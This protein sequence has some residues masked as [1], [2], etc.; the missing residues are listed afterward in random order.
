MTLHR[1]ENH[2]QNL[3]VVCNGLMQLSVIASLNIRII[4]V[5]HPNP[6]VQQP[7]IDLLGLVDGIML[8]RPL[9]YLTLVHVLSRVDFVFTDSGG[10]QEEAL[11]LGKKVLVLRDSTDRP[12]G[13]PVVLEHFDLPHFMKLALGILASNSP[14]ARGKVLC[15][16]DDTTCIASDCVKLFSQ[17]HA[18]WGWEG[19]TQNLQENFRFSRQRNQ[20]NMS[21]V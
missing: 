19:S 6:N 7:I 21:E 1:R 20:K 2:G 15:S 14:D 11:S 13:N 8:T 10:L 18:V 16:E 3:R 4:F 12:E 17:W 9:P 5:L